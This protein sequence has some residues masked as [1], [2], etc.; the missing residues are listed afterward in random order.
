VEAVAGKG[1]A[2]KVEVLVDSAGDVRKGNV[3]M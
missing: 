1:E 2:A 3:D